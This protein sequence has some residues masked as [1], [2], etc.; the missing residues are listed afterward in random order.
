MCSDTHTERWITHLLIFN[1]SHFTPSLCI[2][3][4]KYCDCN[5]K[6]AINALLIEHTS[7]SLFRNNFILR[8][9]CL[10]TPSGRVLIRF[11]PRA[12]LQVLGK[13]WKL[14]ASITDIPAK[15]R[16]RHLTNTSI[17]CHHF[18]R[19]SVKRRMM[20]WLMDNYEYSKGY[21]RTLPWFN[22][23]SLPPPWRN[24]L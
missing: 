2:N 6:Y 11:Y 12:Y 23:R 10:C 9:F 15:I 14:F 17:Q 8:D 4:L 20:E 18:T 21:G 7:T 3:V 5:V 16:N 13:L 22:T 19:P 1:L 24:S